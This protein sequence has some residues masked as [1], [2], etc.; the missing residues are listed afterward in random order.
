M[1]ANGIFGQKGI[2]MSVLISCSIESY[3]SS[4]GKTPPS[5]TYFA[6]PCLIRGTIFIYF[7]GQFA[8]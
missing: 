8:A 7:I 1:E 4:Y 6:F 5:N 3:G 2:K